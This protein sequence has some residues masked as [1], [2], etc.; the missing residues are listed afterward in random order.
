LPSQE[1]AAGNNEVRK[2]GEFREENGKMSINDFVTRDMPLL[3]IQNI[4]ET[5]ISMMGNPMAT[6]LHSV[7]SRK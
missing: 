5:V 3:K 2:G 7:A 1:N 4:K 6:I